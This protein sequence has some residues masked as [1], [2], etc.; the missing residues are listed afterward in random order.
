MPKDASESINQSRIGLLI[1]SGV[2]LSGLV[3][4]AL[5]VALPIQALS[6]FMAGWAATR[7]VRHGA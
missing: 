6:G 7:R 4:P 3:L 1:V 5:V 2:A